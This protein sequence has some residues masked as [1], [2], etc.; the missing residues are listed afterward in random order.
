MTDFNIRW[1]NLLLRMYADDPKE[2][3]TIFFDVSMLVTEIAQQGD[4]SSIVKLFQQ[5]ELSEL[6]PY[7]AM[8]L[9]RNTSAYQ[10]HISNW[11]MFR[12]TAIKH[13]EQSA[14]SDWKSMFVGLLDR[15]KQISEQ[16]QGMRSALNQMLKVHPNLSSS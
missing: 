13:Y 5:I 1:A 10:K 14:D 4:V 6:K 3:R 2:R 9:L 11:E 12:Q 7:F 8:C 15:P 16:G